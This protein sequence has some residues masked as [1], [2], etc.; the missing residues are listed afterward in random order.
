[1][2]TSVS[3]PLGQCPQWHSLAGHGSSPAGVVG[4]RWRGCRV[5]V[6]VALIHAVSERARL[7]SLSAVAI[8]VVN[9]IWQQTTAITLVA[10]LRQKGRPSR[11]RSPHP[12]AHVGHPCES[13]LKRSCTHVLA[14]E[15]TPSTRTQIWRWRSCRRSALRATR[16]GPPPMNRHLCHR[17]RTPRTD[18][19]RA[20]PWGRRGAR[21]RGPTLEPTEHT[22]KGILRGAGPVRSAVADARDPLCPLRHLARGLD[23]DR[24]ITAP[25][26]HHSETSRV[27]PS[28]QRKPRPARFASAPEVWRCHYRVPSSTASRQRVERHRALLEA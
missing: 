11:L 26:T 28:G 9:T 25:R 3:V 21:T 12:Q 16:R 24:I 4:C 18:D 17:C 14:R 6:P 2:G 23:H 13:N 5:I 20:R 1:V 7:S 27:Q 22:G 19:D 8:R 10:D 15:W